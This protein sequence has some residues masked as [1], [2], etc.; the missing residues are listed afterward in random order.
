MKTLTSLNTDAIIEDFRIMGKGLVC[1]V[2]VLK[3]KTAMVSTV[4]L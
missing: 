4:P 2:D 3:S 1:S